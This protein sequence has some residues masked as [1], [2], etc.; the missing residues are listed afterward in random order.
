VFSAP[1]SAEVN[2]GA[3]TSLAIFPVVLKHFWPL[4]SLENSAVFD[5]Y[6]GQRAAEIL[7]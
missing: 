3:L 6:E 5:G 1:V 4:D 7:R 2:S